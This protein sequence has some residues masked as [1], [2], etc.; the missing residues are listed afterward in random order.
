VETENVTN[1]MQGAAERLLDKLRRFI[2]TE[3]DQDE[4]AMFATLLAPGVASAHTDEEVTAFGMTAWS[5][6][7]LPD[8]LVDALDRQGVTVSGLG[9]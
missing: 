1:D 6:A 4:R 7:S 3:L 8:A 5:T 2:A 9:L